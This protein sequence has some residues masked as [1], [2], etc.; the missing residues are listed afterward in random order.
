[1]GEWQLECQLGKLANYNY[2]SLKNH[3]TLSK[4][5]DMALFYRTVSPKSKVYVS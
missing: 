4:N 1:M 5:N 3:V 2:Q